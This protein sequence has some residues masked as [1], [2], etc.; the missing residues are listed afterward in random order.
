[1]KVGK[2]KFRY[3]II[4][5]VDQKMFTAL[6][7][8]WELSL[9]VRHVRRLLVTYRRNKRKKNIASIFFPSAKPPVWNVASQEIIDEAVRLKRENPSRA[10]QHIAEMV[11]DKLLVKVSQS[12][13]RNILLR[14]NC[15]E[16][17]KRERRT[18]VNLEEKITTCGQM[19][20]FDVCEGAWIK[21]YRRVYLIAFLDA[22][23]RY[24]VGWKWVG[25]NSAWNNILVLR[26][27]CP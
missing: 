2:Y 9:S 10:N 14:N 7:A 24:V 5:L 19:V 20:Q 13:I 27:R 25:T 23:S 21:G 12:T 16:R 26:W 1:M 15:Y 11:Q 3:E 4:K 6:E 22:Y 8:A 18:F 17:V